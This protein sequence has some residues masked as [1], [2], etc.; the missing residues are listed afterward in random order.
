MRME[1]GVSSYRNAL[2]AEK[3]VV[4]LHK[5][6]CC[7]YLRFRQDKYKEYSTVDVLIQRHKK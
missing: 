3:Q 1:N 7:V 2:S 5:M 4:I 6:L